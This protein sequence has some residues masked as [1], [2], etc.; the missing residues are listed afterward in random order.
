MERPEELADDATDPL[1]KRAGAVDAAPDRRPGSRAVAGD[2]AETEARASLPWQL[3]PGEIVAARY[4]VLRMLGE[5]GMGQVYEVEDQELH[6]RVAL[7]TI[8]RDLATT[9][10]AEERFKREVLLARRITHPNVCRVLEF[11]YHQPRRGGP[12]IMFLTMELLEGQTLCARLRQVGRLA[13]DQALPLFQQMAAALE[14]AHAAGI[15]HRDFKSANVIIAP[16]RDGERVVV[17]DFGLARADAGAEP[18]MDALTMAGEA[19]GT[20]AYM[21]PEQVEGKP[22]GPPADIYALGVVAFEMVTGRRPFEGET[23]LAVA[24]RRL[25]HP[26]PSPRSLVAD[27][28]PLWDAMILR[29]LERDPRQRFASARDALDSVQPPPSRDAAPSGARSAVPA[30]SWWK[31]PVV[32]VASGA[33]AVVLCLASV[34]LWLRPQARDV[35]RPTEL[36]LP[37]SPGVA[38][39]SVAI[40]GF[41]NTGRP[42]ADWLATGMEEMLRTELASDEK[43]RVVSADSVARVRL[44]LGLSSVDDMPAAKVQ[45]I[46]E[47]V[48]SDLVVVGSYMAIGSGDAARLRLDVRVQDATTGEIVVAIPVEG[49]V[50]GVF[51]LIAASGAKIRDQLGLD[52]LSPAALVGVRASLPRSP[53]ARELYVR[54]LEKLRLYEARSAVELLQAVVEMEPEHAHSHAALA[55]AWGALGYDRRAAEQAAR[56]LELATGLPREERLVIEAGGR[57]YQGEWAQ[58]VEIWRSL[59][60]VFPDNP[61][62]GLRLAGV[63]TDSGQGERAL[64]TLENLRRLNPG[65][66]DDPRLGLAEAAAAK[67][68]TDYARQQRAADAAASRAEAMGARLLY[69]AARLASG[70]A[71]VVQGQFAEGVARSEEAKR[72]FADVGDRA[73]VADAENVAAVACANQGDLDAAEGRFRSALDELRQV[74]HGKGVTRQLQ[75]VANVL[76]AKGDLA[77]ARGAASEALATA[78]EVGDSRLLATALNNLAAIEWDLNDLAAARDHYHEAIDIFRRVGAT[79]YLPLTLCNLGELLM[80]QGDVDA[81]AAAYTE[82]AALGE[83]ISS[84]VEVG[85][86]EL[87][88]ASVERA[89]GNLRSSRSVL[90]SARRRFD[91]VHDAEGLRQALA[92]LAEVADQMGDP[93]AAAAA[94]AELGRLGSGGG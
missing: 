22:A 92:A 79:A 8:T 87:G 24:T 35:A 42:D 20:P 10:G 28:D 77:A 39:R 75:N 74:G 59:Y 18:P 72:I 62:Y 16:A 58:A 71:L 53:S 11:G 12:Q 93:G 47:I 81:A 56:A 84:P 41:R 94:R 52:R 55:D 65:L 61:E 50:G 86:A 23:P 32:R 51:E 1:S 13:T 26:P 60:L 45:R 6:E 70:D 29:C 7:K 14:A 83:Q 4:R 36:S 5:G 38:R 88:L 90:E 9:R 67:V 31:R 49:S 78:R 80:K 89:R 82:A 91:P 30:P 85:Y 3:L 46:G 15:V 27:L 48:G 34:A 37:T 68:L 40:V 64:E 17:T 44:E 57:A 21:A 54:G 73:S 43:L 2:E 33:I 66:A 25:S 63:L 76:S 19:L 69:A